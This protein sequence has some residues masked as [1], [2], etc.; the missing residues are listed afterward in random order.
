MTRKPKRLK[1]IM[2]YV[3]VCASFMLFG[4]F[5]DFLCLLPSSML[6]ILCNQLR[7][8]YAN[9]NIFA[10]DSFE[11]YQRFTMHTEHKAQRKY[12]KT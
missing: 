4:G 3:C 1:S 6:H 11:Q 9:D 5:H 2:C 7:I 10:T 8:P 12:V